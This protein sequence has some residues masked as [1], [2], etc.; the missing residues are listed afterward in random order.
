MNSVSVDILTVTKLLANY[1][2]F[3]ITIATYNVQSVSIESL[4]NGTTNITCYFAQ[5][6]SAT[7]CNVRFLL[8]Q[9]INEINK[10]EFNII[11]NPSKNFVTKYMNITVGEY[12]VSVHD[13]V[14]EEI[15]DNPSFI[16]SMYIVP[17]Q[18]ITIIPSSS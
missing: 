1:L 2:L 18:V 16:I 12:N 13:I 10:D 14:N 4:Q 6:S 17:A 5:N 15:D 3:V 7:G 8:L 11:K 9:S